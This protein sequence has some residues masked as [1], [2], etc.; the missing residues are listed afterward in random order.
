MIFEFRL[1]VRFDLNPN[2][3]LNEKR[4]QISGPWDLAQFYALRFIGL[5]NQRVRVSSCFLRWD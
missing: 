2:F 3:R 4:L 1:K 5:T